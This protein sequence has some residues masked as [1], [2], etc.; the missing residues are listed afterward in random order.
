MK[1]FVLVLLCISPLAIQAQNVQLHYDFGTNRKFW[2]ATFEMFKPD[3]LGST[4]WFAD[5]DFDFPG[6]PRSMSA[7]YLEIS[8]EFYLPWLKKSP[9]WHELAFHLEYNDGFAAFEDSS[10]IMGAASFNSVFLT[11]FCYPVTLGGVTISTQALLR[12][13]RGMNQPDFQLTLVWFQSLFRNKLLFT[14]FVDL[15][16]QDKPTAPGN[17]EL[18]FQTEPQ[19]WYLLNS[20]IGI[21]G[22]AEISRN[23]PYGPNPWQIC[24]TLAIRWEF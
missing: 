11:G 20:H 13:P 23:F 21:G 19:L 18:V 15:W 1:R 10:A 9:T 7:A 14:G 2:T 5:L 22:E 8:R 16:S 12:L 24:P 4:F 17:K 6:Q 3:T